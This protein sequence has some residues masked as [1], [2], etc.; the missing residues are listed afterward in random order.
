MKVRVPTP[1]R[2]YTEQRSVVDAEGA[3]VD[4]V[5]LDLDRQFP[6]IRFRMV[7]EQGRIR[8]HM[9]VFVNEEATR[10]PDAAVAPADELTIMQA[11]SGG[12]HDNGPTRIRDSTSWLTPVPVVERLQL[13]D[14]SWVD[15]VRG[16]M[17][18]ADEVHDELL[19]SEDWEQGRVF[20]YE[21]WIDEPRLSSWQSADA[22]HPALVDAQTWIMKHYGVRFDGVALARYRDQRDSVAFHRDRELRWLDETVIGVLTTGAQRPFLLRPLTGRRA[23]TDDD[24]MRG[25]LDVRPASGD[26]LIM[27]GRTQA[28]WLHAVPKVA[29]RTR[30]RI[31][32]Q[33]RWTSRRGRRDNNPSYYAP[34]YF[35]GPKP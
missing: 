11:L 6:G 3:T 12:A 2:S 10:D 27:G 29:R 22:R 30:S 31:S 5:L 19:A 7:D 25:V 16:F 14:T 34:R 8:R 18:R 13:D 32:A 35:N 24:D 21:R 4:A 26:L 17:P 15:I 1:L 9:R 23:D 28:A 20:R 33:W